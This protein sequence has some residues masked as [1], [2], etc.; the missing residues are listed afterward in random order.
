MGV[1]LEIYNCKVCP[2]MKSSRYYTADSFENVQ[3]WKCT[4]GGL[5][6]RITLHEWNDPI[7]N[8]PEWCFLRA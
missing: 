7:P 5:E 6:K 1:L 3:E 4:K 8:I 2:Y